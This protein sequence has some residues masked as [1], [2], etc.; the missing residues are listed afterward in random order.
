MD[1]A[2]V[3]V[4]T[5]SNCVQCETTKRALVKADIPFEV[6]D[7]EQNPTQLAE[8]TARGFTAAPIV[9]FGDKTWSGY[10]HG[11]I[12]NL[13]QHFQAVKAAQ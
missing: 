12:Q 6:V 13:I 2:K 9:S 10:R 4:Y 3:T 7:L 11:E 5:K 1:L 8:F